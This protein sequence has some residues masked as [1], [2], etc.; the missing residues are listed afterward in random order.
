M[1]DIKSCCKPCIP[2]GVIVFISGVPGVG[3]TTISY[4]LLKRYDEFRVIQE[5]DLIREILRGYNE[6]LND[7]IG[8]S[9]I[10]SEIYKRIYIPDHTKIFNYNE[11]K[12]QCYIMKKP[13]EQIVCRQQRKGIASIIN[14]VHI[15]PEILDGIAQNKNIFY[16][17]LYI[18]KKD[19]LIK[20]L[21]HRD[22]NKYMPYLDVSF[23]ANCSLYNSTDILS[24]ASPSIFRNVDVTYLTVSQVVDSIIDFIGLDK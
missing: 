10:Y 14:G 17:N 15:V 5:T 18:N 11:L 4:E 22:K 16:I 19:I 7:I 3:K 8:N 2:K 9:I 23:Q 1:S 24:K 6:Y 13:I 20:R 12:T 21:A